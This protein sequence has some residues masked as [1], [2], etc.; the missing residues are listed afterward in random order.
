MK[1]NFELEII[2]KKKCLRSEKSHKF[3]RRIKFYNYQQLLRRNLIKKN[4]E[5]QG[6]LC[7]QNYDTFLRG[8]I[9]FTYL[10]NE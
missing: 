5:L 2:K 1:T 10:I 7:L 8:I 6:T 9:L 4:Y 3:I